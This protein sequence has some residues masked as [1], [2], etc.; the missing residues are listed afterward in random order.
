MSQSAELL[1]TDWRRN[2]ATETPRH[3]D[4]FR[5]RSY[6]V[7]RMADAIALD[8]PLPVRRPLAQRRVPPLFRSG[9]MRVMDGLMAFPGVILAIAI[10]AAIGPRVENVIFSLTVV[11]TPR[12]ARVMRSAVLQVRELQ[13]VEAAQAIG[14]GAPRLLVRHI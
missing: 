9:I 11:Y 7:T 13:Y 4:T 3:C 12:L 14:V 10:M 5:P 1:V 8:S 6:A 2:A